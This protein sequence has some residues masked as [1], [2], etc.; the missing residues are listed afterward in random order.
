[1]KKIL[2]LFLIAALV[3]SAAISYANNVSNEISGGVLRL[4]IPANSNSKFDQNIKLKIRDRVIKK[5]GKLLSDAK[6]VKDAE[7]ITNENLINIQKDVNFWLKEI[8]AQYS[9]KVSVENSDFPTKDYDKISL[10]KGNYKAL[11]IVL[12]EGVG[13]NWWCI[14]F[15]PLCFTEGTVKQVSD[16]EYE[17]LKKQLGKRAFEIVTK[18]GNEVLIKFKI[19]ELINSVIGWLFSQ[20]VIKY[21]N[22]EILS[23]KDDL[24][25]LRWWT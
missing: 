13:D 5:Y 15:P 12:G 3:F 4:H 16:K 19:I 18:D 23:E 2:G 25:E 9:A 17:I 7:N 11:K 22:N 21:F 6:S 10:P 24:N 20:K 1:M 8:G 14:M